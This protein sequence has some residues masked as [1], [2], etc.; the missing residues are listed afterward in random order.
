VFFFV[1]LGIQHATR[2]RHIVI[3]GLPGCTKFLHTILWTVRFSK[4]INKQKISKLKCVFGVSL[5]LLSEMFLNMSNSAKATNFVTACYEPVSQQ[6]RSASRETNVLLL[7]I[8]F[9]KKRPFPV[10][11]P[12]QPQLRLQS[13]GLLP[14]Q[15]QNIQMCHLT[16]ST[17]LNH[18]FASGTE[19]IHS[20]PYTFFSRLWMSVP[21]TPSVSKNWITARWACLEESMSR[22]LTVISLLFQSTTHCRYR[23][24]TDR[25]SVV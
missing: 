9:K 16:S 10:T 23:V 19:C 8:H 5:Q 7:N 24:Y 4:N 15:Y 21:I 25:K 20:V 1:A 12:L 22:S 13:F 14:P 18:I 2:K 11:Q 3:C 6:I 17:G